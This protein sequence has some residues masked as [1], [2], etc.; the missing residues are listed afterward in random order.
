MEN[1]NLNEKREFVV[2]CARCNKRKEGGEWKTITALEKNNITKTKRVSHG[3]CPECS[4][5]ALEEAQT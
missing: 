5:K 3:M 1:S 2:L 4:K